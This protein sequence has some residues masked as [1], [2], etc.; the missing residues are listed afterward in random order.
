MLSSPPMTDGPESQDGGP[1]CDLICSRDITDVCDWDRGCRKQNVGRVRPPG[2]EVWYNM[3]FAR[4]I[5]GLVT[6]HQGF[7]FLVE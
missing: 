6:E 7:D 4:N 2:E 5:L 1:R 3:E